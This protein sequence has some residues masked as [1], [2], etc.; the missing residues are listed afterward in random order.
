MN[1][2][3]NDDSFDMDYNFGKNFTMPEPTYGVAY[4]RYSSGKQ[5]ENSIEY[6]RKR[7]HAY[8]AMRNILICKEYIDRAHTG[9]TDRRDAFREMLRDAHENPIWDK[10]IVF[11]FS[12]YARN[13]CDALVYRNT[14]NDLGISV[15]SITQEYGNTPEGRLMETITFAMDAY[16]SMVN[17]VHTHAGMLNKA[18]RGELCGG[19]QP[20]GYDVN[21][22]GK[23]VINPTEAEAVRKIFDMY[24]NNY[25][26]HKMAEQ[27]N[28]AGYRTKT[29]KLFGKNSF[30]TILSQEKYTG[31]Y[32]W[33]KSRQKNSK[34]RRNSHAYK[35]L[36]KQVRK[37]DIYPQIITPAQFERVQE[38]RKSAARGNVSSKGKH[39]YMLSG[40]KLMK[41]ANCGAYM[42]GTKRKSHDKEYVTYYCPNHR[43]GECPT[44]EIKGEEIDTFVAGKLA[45]AFYNRKDLNAIDAALT[46]NDDVNRLKQKKKGLD[47]RVRHALDAI[48]SAPSDLLSERLR[49]LDAQKKAV[50][51]ELQTLINSQRS[52]SKDNIRDVSKLFARHLIESDA[53]E[54][55]EYLKHAIQEI[56]V[57]NDAVSVTFTDA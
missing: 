8:C 1:Y 53:L 28:Q 51:A 49:D 7:V 9:T 36:N 15:I 57:S 27:L 19:M 43:H 26:Y 46:D 44:K 18:Q 38:L 17:G 12:R 25:S 45:N 34:G 55:R 20:L 23:P 37:E 10:V 50:E 35:P 32:I 39:H 40:L 54:V 31:I 11:S 56:V 33:N 14:L 24:E 2:Y 16:A 3:D 41:C 13:D 42:I 22:L 48:E 47:V 21:A 30:P 29:G 6:Q 52:L 5:K 4:L